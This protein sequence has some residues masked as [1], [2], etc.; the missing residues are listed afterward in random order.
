MESYTGVYDE[1]TLVL[2][3]HSVDRIYFAESG[4]IRLEEGGDIVRTCHP[5]DPGW[6]GIQRALIPN[7]GRWEAV[8]IDR[9]WGFGVI[10]ERVYR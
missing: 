8:G 5:G 9:Q 1:L 4:V 6:S 10:Y 2:S 7:L 3:Y